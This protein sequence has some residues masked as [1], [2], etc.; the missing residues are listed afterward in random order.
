MSYSLTDR[1]DNHICAVQTAREMYALIRTLR[2]LNPN[3]DR[4]FYIYA[5]DPEG[6]PNRFLMGEVL[7]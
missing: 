2:A 7:R 4:K 3:A 5:D 6:E 1:D